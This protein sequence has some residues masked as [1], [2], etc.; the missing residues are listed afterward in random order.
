[1]SGPVTNQ[2]GGLPAA[3]IQYGIEAGVYPSDV[4]A[5]GELM[6]IIADDIL[7]QIKVEETRIV[8]EFMASPPRP[9]EAPRCCRQCQREYRFHMFL[10]WLTTPKRWF[11]GS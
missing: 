7:A 5:E 4:D 9:S 11:S 6:A 1:M 2:W 3:L 8:K 10:V